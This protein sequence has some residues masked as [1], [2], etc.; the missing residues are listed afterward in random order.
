MIRL[1]YSLSCGNVTYTSC[2]DGIGMN[3]PLRRAS[4]LSRA[5]STPGYVLTGIHRAGL[6]WSLLCHV[7]RLLDAYIAPLR[8]DTCML[9][10]SR[11]LIHASNILDA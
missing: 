4:G 1:L 7:T 3:V 5:T 9:L 11:Y 6:P 10:S 2:H 8:V